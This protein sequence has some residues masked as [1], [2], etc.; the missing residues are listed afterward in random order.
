MRDH[1]KSFEDD[2]FVRIRKEFSLDPAMVHLSMLSLSSHP[3]SVKSAIE[4]YRVELDRS[5]Y[6]FLRAN[7]ERLDR[8]AR[9]SLAGLLRGQAC[10]IILCQNTSVGLNLVFNGLQLNE[11]DEVITSIH[12]HYSSSVGLDC[13]CVRT[14][15]TMCRVRLY[16]DG[17][18]VLSDQLVERTVAA[19]TGRTRLIVLTWVH[20]S[21]GLR[22]PIKTLMRELNQ[23]NDGR[24]ERRQILLCLDATH[25]VG[26]LNI[27][28]NDLR[29]TFI[30]SACHKWLCGPRGTAFVWGDDT[31]LSALSP[32]V[33]SFSSPLM[34]QFLG[35]LPCEGRFWP[36]EHLSPGGFVC[37]EHR[38]AIPSAIEVFNSLGIQQVEERLLGLAG[39]LKSAVIANPRLRLITPV[40]PEDS[41]GIVCFEKPGTEPEAVFEALLDQGI[42]G[43]VSP[44]S[45]PYVRLT[46]G[47]FTS[48]ED[49]DRATMA[50]SR[51]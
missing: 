16:E 40:Q 37:F 26:V 51:I 5:P 38:W 45:K 1:V 33:P 36:G 47:I 15:A 7:G 17:G 19:V 27:D 18:A 20:S 22:L 8:A 14:G 44:Y 3:S 6:L 43:S 13:V 50:L 23:L 10:H 39:G 25:A 11:G 46:P 35:K 30:V 32:I 24:D 12:D 21:T 34:T 41:A 31:A 29:K 28:I 48:A 49:I 42:V 2:Q 4:R 9:Q